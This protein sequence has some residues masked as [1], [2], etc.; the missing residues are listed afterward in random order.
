MPGKT[1]LLAEDNAHDEELALLTLRD[2]RISND[3]VVARDGVEALNFLFSTGDYAGCDLSMMPAVIFLDLKLPKVDGLQVVRRLRNDKRTR[4]LA[5]V[6]LTS[7]K[8]EE[9]IIGSY[10]LGVDSYVREPV[11]FSEFSEAVRQLKLYW[12][13]LNEYPQPERSDPA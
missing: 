11:D 6:I 8:E 13:L 2:N 10:S 9:D 5:V 1:I 4:L 12:L 7:S 3:V